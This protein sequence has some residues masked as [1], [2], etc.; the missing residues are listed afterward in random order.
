MK[1]Y[2]GIHVRSHTQVALVLFFTAA[3][4]LC[5]AAGLTIIFPDT[6][7]SAIWRI[8]PDEF[9]QFLN[10]RPWT[11]IGFLLLSGLMGATA[12]GCWNGRLW[13]WR[14]AIAIFAANGVG[15]GANIH[16]SHSGR[17]YWDCSCGCDRILADTSAGEGRIPIARIGLTKTGATLVLAVMRLHGLALSRRIAPA[18]LS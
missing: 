9:A 2:E 7:L 17:V 8:K 10:L 3:A 12:W 1:F 6:A 15:R 5:M 4:V 18:A 11:G 14:M 13:G 16:G